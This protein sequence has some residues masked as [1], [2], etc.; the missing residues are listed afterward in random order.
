MGNMQAK[1]RIDLSPRTLAL[2]SVDDKVW[3][4]IPEENLFN[5][6]FTIEKYYMLMSKSLTNFKDA[7]HFKA[8]EQIEQSFFPSYKD[9]FT[10]DAN[11]NSNSN[12]INNSSG[13]SGNSGNGGNSNGSGGGSVEVDVQQQ[14]QQA[15]G[16]GVSNNKPTNVKQQ[17]QNT[18]SLSSSKSI[19]TSASTMSLLGS[20]IHTSAGGSATSTTAASNSSI[21]TRSA[22]QSRLNSVH[23][24]RQ[25]PTTT[26]TTTTT[27]SGSAIDGVA[28]KRKMVAQENTSSS[29]SSNKSPPQ[30]APGSPTVGGMSPPTSR[31]Q[32][33]V[34]T[35]ASG[36]GVAAS[37]T[38]STAATATTNPFHEELKNRQDIP[39]Y[40]IEEDPFHTH[41][42]TTS[43]ILEDLYS[44]SNVNTAYYSTLLQKR[45]CILKRIHLA[46]KREIA[47]KKLFDSVYHSK[48]KTR[49]KKVHA[50]PISIRIACR[51]FITTLQEQVFEQR[52]SLPTL[53]SFNSMIRELPPLSMAGEPQDCI[54][55]LTKWLLSAINSNNMYIKRESM[56]SLI[57]LALS[58]GALSA[59][60]YAL[61]LII[62]PDKLP[63]TGD[64]TLAP[65]NGNS[66]GNTQTQQQQQQQQQQT[67]QQR[68]HPPHISTFKSSTHSNSTGNMND[69]LNTPIT[70]TD[71]SVWNKDMLTLRLIPF[72]RQLEQWKVDLPL[73]P[74]TRDLLFATWPILWNDNASEDS[75]SFLSS[76][77][78]N[79]A[80]IT[81]DG[82]YIYIHDSCGL[83]KIG[84]GYFGTHQGR[85]YARNGH[86]YPR[87]KGWL[88]SVGNYLYYRSPS[89]DQASFI[90]IDP[91]TLK[92]VGRVMQDGT[93]SF[94]STNNLTL[95]FG[96]ETPQ[97][98]VDANPLTPQYQITTRSPMFTD[99][100]YLYILTLQ[101][102]HN[103]N[104]KQFIV[105]MY[106]PF[107][108]F[109]HVKRIELHYPDTDVNEEMVLNPAVLESGSFYT[110]G[111]YL[112]VVLPPPLSGDYSTDIK[113]Y[114]CRA[115]SL[116]DGS[117]LGNYCLEN[118]PIGIASTY[119]YVNNVIWNYSSSESEVGR[120]GNEGFGPK[121]NF[122]VP[123]ARS[124]STSASP[125]SIVSGA[126]G[127]PN[128]P[129]TQPQPQPGT[130]ST[131]TST[132]KSSTTITTT[133]NATA[134][135]TI[136]S[137]TITTSM[138]ESDDNMGMDPKQ[139]VSTVLGIL[140]RLA[141]DYMPSTSENSNNS[142]PST[143]HHLYKLS[144]PYSV[145]V[146][147]ETFSQLYD[148]LKH[149]QSQVMRI[150]QST[151]MST[152]KSIDVLRCIIYCLRLLKVNLFRLT[153]NIRSL[154]RSQQHYQDSSRDS[155]LK[156]IDQSFLHQL[157]DLLLGF[158]IDGIEGSIGYGTSSSMGS[159][160]RDSHTLPELNSIIEE[161]CEVLTLGLDLFYPTSLDK[162]S[163]VKMLLERVMSYRVAAMS[164]S[165][166]SATMLDQKEKGYSI[167]LNSVLTLLANHPNAS[168]FALPPLV[169]ELPSPFSVVQL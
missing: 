9:R 2:T 166:Q 94:A 30:Q 8:I 98:V 33:V 104:N 168:F 18:H 62:M 34:A 65:G 134:T 99:G 13:N 108:A 156:C 68:S 19:P 149:Y 67:Q 157:R 77:H 125:A 44:Q 90:V 70:V 15:E 89:T 83:A 64:T 26:T 14:Q 126:K 40:L 88:A 124:S 152:P 80:T 120:Y 1:E 155:L 54:E 131:N 109:K 145:E 45:L 96:S 137:T 25:Q 37:A 75:L 103:Y 164:A 118:Q 73:S 4:C 92:E 154:E 51:L 143:T 72:I 138:V 52:I 101:R 146:N 66:S 140:S 111:H 27:T 53:R 16:L 100:R 122:P 123:F 17:Q 29:S 35:T 130:S 60:L 10:L 148:I 22:T 114:L 119:D 116:S 57:S 50:P 32:G 93:G 86:W 55:S 39:V 159:A 84:T 47:R 43:L 85:I 142:S 28:S 97:S 58:Q 161:S 46:L 163:F 151:A 136:I 162:A 49:T 169:S 12:S 160:S 87:E 36:V 76:P 153:S 110:N 117:L 150:G 48:A 24:P 135:A 41:Q 105:D 21:F 95:P 132:S 56:E 61:S 23:S 147:F 144:E 11:N 113:S 141:V 91:I 81:S 121:H 107:V 7:D 42:V 31:Q 20:P 127:G 133:S 38:G 74:L 158:I 102:F 167:L 59:I 129:Q 71:T 69:H 165:D 5:D 78:T 112:M 82:D 63:A 3:L 6:S 115:F 106:D 128:K 139:V 79:N